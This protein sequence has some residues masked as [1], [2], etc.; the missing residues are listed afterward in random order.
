VDGRSHRARLSRR[1]EWPQRSQCFNN[2]WK[3]FREIVLVPAI[4]ADMASMI[5]FSDR[6][7][8]VPFQLKEPALAVAWISNKTGE[9][10]II[11]STQRHFQQ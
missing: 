2:R 8:A 6:A 1:Q 11:L 4:E 10:V 7:K 5:S 9:G 3:P